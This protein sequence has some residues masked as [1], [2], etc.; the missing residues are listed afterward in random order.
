MIYSYHTFL[1]PFIWEG[2]GK[3]TI[4][5]EDFKAFF[6][7]NPNWESTNMTD[8]FRIKSNPEIRSDADAFLF[9]KEYQYFHPYA[10]KAIYGFEDGIV[11]NY[12][13]RPY[14]VRN[15][16]HYYI[17][18]T[19]KLPEITGDSYREITFDLLINSI[20]L[21]IYNTGIAI[22]ILEGENH[23]LTKDG[24]PQNNLNAVKAINDYGRR[25]SLPFIPPN[26]NYS[27]SADNLTLSINGIGE[28]VSDFKGCIES[29]QTKEDMENSISLTHF[30]DFIKNILSFGGRKS[31]TSKSTNSDECCFVY[32]ALDDRMFVA[33]YIK[34]TK[35]SDAMRARGNDNRPL[36]YTQNNLSKSLYE[37]LCVDPPDNCCCMDPQMREQE[38]SKAVYTRWLD[39]GTLTTCT[40][41]ALI[42]L[43]TSN[44]PSHM[45][46]SFLTQYVQMCCL[47]LAQRASIIN[48]RRIASAVSAH[49]EERGRQIKLTTVSHLMTLQERFAAFQNQLNLHEVTPE[50]QGIELYGMLMRNSF[51]TEEMNSLKEQLDALSNAANTSLDYNFNRFALIFAIPALLWD[52]CAFLMDGVWDTTQKTV[53]FPYLSV[54][55]LSILLVVGLLIKYRRKK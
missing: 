46:D 27:I 26:P 31:F 1:F 22:F 24:E 45:D 48:F 19:M 43:T 18:K 3:K 44:A 51:I 10:R 8:E 36:F 2:R 14:D 52:F 5:T 39:M 11:F 25:I 29:T 16:A 6:D 42:T 17:T 35:E 30:C 38:I 50:L 34:D 53:S 47:C 21:K 13:F 15:K 40:N 28:F 23:G 33:S 41:Q 49:V 4:S 12:A 55:A 9:Y 54:F 32:S 7:Q 20:Q 37:L